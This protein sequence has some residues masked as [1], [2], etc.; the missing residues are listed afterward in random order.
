MME[1]MFLYGSCL[2]LFCILR[3]FYPEAKPWT[4]VDHIIT[5]IDGKFYDITGS[6]N[7]KGYTPYAPE[8]YRDKVGIRKS[9]NQQYKLQYKFEL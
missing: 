8:S 6:V 1:H 3:S 4:N 7:N 9:F 5:E 2:N